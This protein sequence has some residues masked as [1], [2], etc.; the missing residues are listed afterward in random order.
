VSQDGEERGS[1]RTQVAET[2]A[3]REALLLAA[4]LAALY[5]VLVAAPLVRGVPPVAGGVAVTVLF[6]AAALG[7][8]ALGARVRLGPPGELVSMVLALGLWWAVGG[9]GEREGTVRLLALPGADVIFVLACVLAGRLLSRIVRERNIMLPI[10]IVLALTDVFT[11]FVGPVALALT[12]APE[13]VEQLSMKLPEVGS[14]APEGAAGLSHFATLG[15]GDIIFAA[16]LLAGAARFGLNFRATFWWILGTV[17]V[18][19][20]LFVAVPGIPPMPVLPLMAIAFLIAN[21]GRFELSR[22]ERRITIVAFIFVGALLAGL[23]VLAHML[24]AR[25]PAPPPETPPA[26][27]QPQSSDAAQPQSP[28]VEQ[29]QSPAVEQPQS[30]DAAQPQ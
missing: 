5:G 27:E 22:E 4:L 16:L 6:A 21:R 3:R 28:A 13:L 14:A 30:P 15:L 19:L 26:V 23:G 25:L 10:A 20:A 2:T 7:I 1:E 29:P 11:V 17:V 18:G 8:A 12:H 9:L 24:V